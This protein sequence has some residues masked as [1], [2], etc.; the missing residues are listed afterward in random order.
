MQTPTV[1]LMEAS[2]QW[3]TRPDDQRFE[4][5]EALAESVNTRKEQSWTAAARM[6]DLRAVADQGKLAV[7]LYDPSTSSRRLCEPT[8]W[9]FSQLAQY[10]GAPAAYL[11]DL[12]PEL[13]AINLQWGFENLAKREDGL[14]LAQTNGHNLIRS[15]TSTSYGRI[16]DAQVVRNVQKVN[17]NGQWKIPAASYATTNPK[18]ATTLYASDRDVFIFL[19]DDEHPIDV[20]GETFFRG[21]Y[22]WNSETGS[23]TFGLTTFLYR[24]V[25]DNRII[26]G[27]TDVKQLTI[28][29]TG[30]APERFVYEGAQYLR[31]YANEGTA[32][33]A[34]KI[35]AAKSAEIPVDLNEKGSVENWLTKRGFTKT[36]AKAA[37]DAANAEEGKAR[38][39]WEIVQGITAHA[40]SIPFADARIEV[41]TAAGKLLD[42]ATK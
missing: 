5:L 16:W 41:E 4:S 29:H 21:F 40:R 31:A 17:S 9:G 1:N 20:D 23:A 36:I 30:G 28:R 12:P 25:C 13:A 32:Q 14:I 27:C 37:V 8:N 18:R 33:I 7:E 42:A 38:T 6:K 3:R 15:V 26:W 24:R 11:R 39:V 22:C 10:A 35:H 19:V 34:A 2:H